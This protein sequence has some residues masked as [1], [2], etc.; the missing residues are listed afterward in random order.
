MKMSDFSMN[1]SYF[2]KINFREGK[3]LISNLIKTTR[4]G[5]I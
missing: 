3:L 5:M 4:G 2:D 1:K